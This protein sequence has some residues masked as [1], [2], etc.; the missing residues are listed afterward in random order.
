[1]EKKSHDESK[2]TIIYGSNV[3]KRLAKMGKRGT[4]FIVFQGR[5][6]PITRRITIGRDKGNA[7]TLDDTL[8]SRRHALI[9]KIGSEFFIED[10]GSTNGTYVNKKRIPADKYVRL[11]PT[12]TILIGRTELSLL[13]CL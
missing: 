8:V 4:T 7:I 9:Q 2:E 6:V 10:L 1:M 3:G 13:H 11:K 12:D 5:R